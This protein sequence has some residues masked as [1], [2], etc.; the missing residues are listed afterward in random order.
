LFGSLPLRR[1][2]LLIDAFEAR[3]TRRAQVEISM[4]ISAQSLSFLID[5]GFDRTVLATLLWNAYAA[6]YSSLM[7]WFYRAFY[8]KPGHE[9]DLVLRLASE[10]K[11]FNTQKWKRKKWVSKL[12]KSY[13]AK[14]S[15]GEVFKLIQAFHGIEIFFQR[16]TEYA[17]WRKGLS[18]PVDADRN[19]LEKWIK[20]ITREAFGLATEAANALRWAVDP[21]GQAV[22]SDEIPPDTLALF[23]YFDE[24]LGDD[25][26]LAALNLE[27][28]PKDADTSWQLVP[29]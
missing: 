24:L 22:A 15:V 2:S 23:A 26:V 14:Q 17:Q 16:L 19:A 3:E 27:T 6:K 9:A 5:N 4:V 13:K 18:A 21:A 29:V 25:Q 7:D 11:G 8:K 12:G 20:E 1:K 28:A 10:L